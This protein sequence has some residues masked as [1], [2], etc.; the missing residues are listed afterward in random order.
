M[1]ETTLCMFIIIALYG[2]V[3]DARCNDQSIDEARPVIEVS[4][5]AIRAFY[6]ERIEDQIS[7]FMEEYPKEKSRGPIN[8]FYSDE[9]IKIRINVFNEGNVSIPRPANGWFEGITIIIENVQTGNT[10]ARMILS[11]VKEG[12]YK[13]NRGCLQR[14]MLEP[15]EGVSSEDEY[16]VQALSNEKMMPGLYRV[17]IDS[18]SIHMESVGGRQVEPI[19]KCP[20]LWV[21]EP[22]TSKEK[23]IALCHRGMRA[24]LGGETES[25][26]RKAEADFVTAMEIDADVVCARHYL[27]GIYI[28]S[29]QLVKALNIIEELYRRKRIHGQLLDEIRN[30]LNEQKRKTDIR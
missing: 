3:D 23:A 29:N 12:S 2:I 22:R 27:A 6:D 16:D 18:K 30:M 21:I 11:H 8:I 4:T 24:L 19:L 15:G 17:L 9:M 5:N 28:K 14:E 1:R 10:T 7:K 26:M 25:G 13:G 20:H